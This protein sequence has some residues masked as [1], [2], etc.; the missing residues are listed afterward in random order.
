MNDS[1]PFVPAGDGGQEQSCLY[2]GV[3]FAQ[4]QAQP[5]LKATVPRLQAFQFGAS[6]ADG[7]MARASPDGRPDDPRN[8][9]EEDCKL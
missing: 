3:N 9:P 8:P 5:L 4:V 6:R 1:G 2:C 7:S